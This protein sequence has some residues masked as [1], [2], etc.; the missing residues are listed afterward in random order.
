[1][2]LSYRSKGWIVA[3]AALATN[4][5]LGILYS[6][7][8]IQKALVNE[9]GWTNT[10]ASLPYTV[11]IATF[12][13]MMIFAGRAQDKYGPKPVAFL[14][15][16]L[17][18]AGLIASSFTRNPALMIITFGILGGMGIG[19]GYSAVTPCAIKWFGPKK[20]GIISG[21]V[22]SGV[23]LSPVYIAPLTNSLLKTHSIEQ[24]FLFL[25]LFTLAGVTLFSL[26]LRN[27]PIAISTGTS[28]DKMGY[29]H[30]YSWQKMIRT[31][32]FLLLWLSYLMSAAA[33]LMLLGHL[34]GIA[35]VQ[36]KWQ[37][38]FILVVILS[39]FNA[40][41]RVSGGF[42][43]D[44]AGRINALLIVFLLQA[45][46]M[47]MF[48]FYQSI[49]A[50]IAGAVFAGLSYGA[51]FALFPAVTAEFY[52]IR[53]LGVNYGLVFTGWGV[54][55]IIGPVIGGMVADITGTYNISYII[56]AFMLVTGALL[57]K[58][59]KSPVLSYKT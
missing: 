16:I 55:G 6:W 1:M 41:G 2:E 17:F 24:T 57:V 43:S 58:K 11:C 28:S 33:G 14:G 35:S 25:G 34:A 4:L 20:K 37:A 50:L 15:G 7:S 46:N 38:G 22:V 53:N 13:V 51:L 44:K 23:G 3:I 59:I 9:W 40:L 31:R 27:P 54:A 21:I 5:I 12:A 30:D 32:P 49:P 18:G 8:I 52:G 45:A 36:A 39:V 29:S 48:S 19:F 47:F 42:L 56:S 26:L 10:Q